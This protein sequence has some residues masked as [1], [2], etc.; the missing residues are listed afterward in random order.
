MLNID[1]STRRNVSSVMD[2][3]V[4]TMANWTDAGVDV[5]NSFTKL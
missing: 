3:L 1:G 2:R 4:R 5:F